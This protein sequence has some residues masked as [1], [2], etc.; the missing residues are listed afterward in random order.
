M[1]EAANGQLGACPLGRA[2]GVWI[3]TGRGRAQVTPIRADCRELVAS[4]RQQQQQWLASGRD[5]AGRP[6]QRER[7][8][9]AS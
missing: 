7:V 1:M 6:E 5:L 8:P 3:Q 2:C 4:Q 9:P